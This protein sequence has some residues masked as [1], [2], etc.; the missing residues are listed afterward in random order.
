MHYAFDKWMGKT[1]PHA[2]FERYA[3]DAVIHCRTRAEAE[4]ILAALDKRM[5]ERKLA[6]HPGKT[7]IVCCKDFER[8]AKYENVS[9]DFLGYT[10]KPRCTYN[11][12]RGR[13]FTSFYRQ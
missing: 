11:K 5:K 2:P 10:F 1:F 8:K 13:C 7:P 6:L 3:D 9:F 12:S 4:A